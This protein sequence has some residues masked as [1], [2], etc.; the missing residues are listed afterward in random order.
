MITKS[1]DIPL[2]KMRL[3]IVVTEDFKKDRE[4]INKKY[5][6]DFP[7]DY[8]FLGISERRSGHCFVMLNI[9]KH[10]K[11]YSAKTWKEELLATIAHEAV[12][13]CN[14]V[15]IA[16]GLKLDVNNDESQAY[17]TD[18][19]FREIYKTCKNL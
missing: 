10:K 14:F 3:H 13:I 2:Y 18:W 7:E 9:E 6:Q 8:S 17:L 19:I 12:H 11:N 16:R 5:H 1:L 15:H 4:V